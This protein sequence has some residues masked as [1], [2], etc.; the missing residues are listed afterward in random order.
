M[1]K[2]KKHQ[3]VRRSSKNKNPNPKRV[4][5]IVGHT[6]YCCFPEAGYNGCFQHLASKLSFVQLY[7]L[8]TTKEVSVRNFLY[9]A[10]IVAALP[11][12]YNFAQSTEWEM[13]TGVVL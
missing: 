1:T 7:F 9:Q 3:P 8:E 11:L 13:Q 12:D 10:A 4:F 5:K 2:N 6:L